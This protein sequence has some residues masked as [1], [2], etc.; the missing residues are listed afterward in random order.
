MDVFISPRWN[1]I[2]TMIWVPCSW[3]LVSIVQRGQSN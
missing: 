3:Y 2:T 1:S